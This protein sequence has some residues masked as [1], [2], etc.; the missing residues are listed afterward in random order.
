MARLVPVRFAH[1]CCS[2][3]YIFGHAANGDNYRRRAD[4]PGSE[5]WEP[6]VPALGAARRRSDGVATVKVKPAARRL[7]P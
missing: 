3:G 4:A 1:M 5:P 2:R 6:V 7:R